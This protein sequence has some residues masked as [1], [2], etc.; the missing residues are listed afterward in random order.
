MTIKESLDVR[1][2]TAAHFLVHSADDP[3][4]HFLVKALAEMA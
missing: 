2:R 4:L 3:L 1:D